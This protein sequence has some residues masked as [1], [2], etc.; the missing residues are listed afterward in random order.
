MISSHWKIDTTS[1]QIPKSIRIGKTIS[2]LD[3]WLAERTED[4]P[5]RMGKTTLNFAGNPAAH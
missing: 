4:L 2:P 1:F 5:L 3:G